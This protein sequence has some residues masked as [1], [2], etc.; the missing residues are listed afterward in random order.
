[1][2]REQEA[3]E[4]PAA[5]RRATNS[6]V[7][8]TDTRLLMGPALY[9][10][11]RATAREKPPT[12]EE[13]A[14]NEEGPEAP[15]AEPHADL[16]P[17]TREGPAGDEEGPEKPE[18]AP[19]AAI[20]PQPSEE[21]PGAE[22]E[23]PPAQEAPGADQGPPPLMSLAVTRPR[24]N[25][26]APPPRKRAG[27]WNCGAGHRYADCPAPRRRP[28]CYGCGAVGTTLAGCGR[29]GPRYLLEG[30]QPGYR[31]P[32]DRSRPAP[33]GAG[34]SRP[35]GAGEPETPE[36]TDSEGTFPESPEIV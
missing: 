12:T 7:T 23:R 1:M 32:R 17:P 5:E 20:E 19:H 33:S 15:E 18:A 36:D 10:C 29:C 25:V 16:E 30:P 8:Q 28:F 34:P 22:A 4:G 9:G 2:L 6:V 26:R 11:G 35:E 3:G 13:P 27:C 14:M 24:E 31:G 21:A